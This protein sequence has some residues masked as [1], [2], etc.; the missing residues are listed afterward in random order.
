MNLFHRP[1]VIG[2]VFLLLQP[3]DSSACSFSPGHA[4]FA[5]STR[6]APYSGDAP[7]IPKVSVQSLKRGYDD[8]NGASCS[9]A[10]ILTVV[11]SK[12]EEDREVGYM[13]KLV[14]GS[15]HDTVFLDSILAPIELEEGVYG[16]YFVWLDSAG[17]IE[18]Q[19]EVRAVS[20]TG[21]EGA[22]VTLTAQSP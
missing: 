9:D 2:A 12:G 5:F 4:S 6:H 1:L 8:G 16:F 13:F 18:A 20:R 11:L 17:P 3:V 7:P 21:V 22:A 19:F 10:G 14:S 15:F